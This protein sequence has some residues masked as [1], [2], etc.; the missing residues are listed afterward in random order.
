[1]ANA[2]MAFETL[3]YP[4]DHPDLVIAKA[5]LRKLLALNEDDGYV[6]P[7]LSPIWD[8]GLAAQALI[9]AGADPDGNIVARSMDCL[10][11]RQILDTYGYWTHQSPHVRPGGWAFRSEERRVGKECVSQCI[12]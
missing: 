7:C 1:M 9:E 4:K 10:A 12:S 2:V 5:S 8:T 6:Q 3:G 11:D